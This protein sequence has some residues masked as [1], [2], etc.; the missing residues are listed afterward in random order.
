VKAGVRLLN[1]RSAILR[2]RTND[3]DEMRFVLDHLDN[4]I[5]A[6]Q[7]TKALY[8]V[9]F[10][11]LCRNDRQLKRLDRVHG[12]GPVSAVKILATVVDAQRFARTGKYWA[13][14][15]LVKNAKYSGGRYYGKRE[16]HY[17]RTLKSVYKTAAQ[18]ALRGNNPV[19]EYYDTLI[20]AGQAPHNARH[21]V[22]RYL[23]QVTYGM[24]KT[25][26]PYDPYRWRKKNP[27]QSKVA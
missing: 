22:A 4:D 2:A 11:D 21:Q 17:N 9:K 19:H 25:N 15:G 6:Y 16:A 18:G 7:K 27:A 1:Q 5:T 24:L 12:I 8:E 3:R 23:A 10:E 20:A 26:T 14:C 13:Y